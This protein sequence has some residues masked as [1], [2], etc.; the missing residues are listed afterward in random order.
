MIA[1]GFVVDIG[2]KFS[3]RSSGNNALTM[4]QVFTVISNASATAIVGTFHNLRNGQVITVNGSSLQA[5]YTGG[6][7]N[8]LTLAVMPAGTGGE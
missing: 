6:D 2:A 4:G 5:S 1:N 3:R 7:G 8:D